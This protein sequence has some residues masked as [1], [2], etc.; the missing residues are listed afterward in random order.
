MLLT[1]LE[2]LP[3]LMLSKDLLPPSSPFLYKLVFINLISL[4]CSL[5]LGHI[6]LPTD[7]QLAQ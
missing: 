6:L 5:H 7:K 3:L 4:Q 1:W 2:W